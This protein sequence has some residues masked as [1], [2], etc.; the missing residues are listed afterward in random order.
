M[1]QEFVP[2]KLRL[3]FRGE[4]KAQS[5]DTILNNFT[6]RHKILFSNMFTTFIFVCEMSAFVSTDMEM[7]G[8]LDG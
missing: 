8:T 4:N 3:L 6:L 1:T 2:V 5:K 7:N